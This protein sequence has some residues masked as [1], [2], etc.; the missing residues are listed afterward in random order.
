MAAS[1]SNFADNTPAGEGKNSKRRNRNESE[2]RR[3]DTFNQLIGELASLVAKRNRKI[4][5]IQAE[6]TSDEALNVAVDSKLRITT[7]CDLPEIVHLYLD[8]LGAG[9]FCMQC[10]GHIEHASTSFAILFDDAISNSL[11]MPLFY[12][13]KKRNFQIC[14]LQGK[15]LF[16][17]LD[18]ESAKSFSGALSVEALHSTC[19]SAAIQKREPNGSLRFVGITVPLSNRPESEVTLETISSWERRNSNF[20]V[21]YNTEFVCTDA[22]GCQLL[23]YSRL[24]LLGTSG[25]DYIHVDDLPQVAESHLQLIKLGTYQV[26]PHRLQTKSHQWIWVDCMAVI[27]GTHATI[28]EVRCNYRVIDMDSVRKFKETTMFVKARSIE[29][30]LLL[31]TGVSSE[32]NS[33]NPHCT[34][35]VIST[36]VCPLSVTSSSSSTVG[37]NESALSPTA[38]IIEIV[39]EIDDSFRERANDSIS[40]IA[41]EKR[42]DSSCTAKVVV[43]PLP[44]KRIRKGGSNELS[45]NVQSASSGH[46]LS[47]LSSE[48][49]L[50]KRRNQVPLAFIEH[51]PLPDSKLAAA[52]LTSAF[53]SNESCLNISNLMTSS[54]STSTSAVAPKA[55]SISPMYQQVWEELQRRSEE[56]RQQVFQKEMELRELHLKRFLASLHDDTC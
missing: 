17:L 44:S 40:I 23:G 14:E 7:G 55:L 33:L 24:D 48:A 22:E 34:T 4:D 41:P 26:R 56:L 53:N 6:S 25:Y 54:T 20:T 29:V 31:S 36:V 50:P 51:Y 11:P 32:S 1:N 9:T 13:E 39:N 49:S 43:T 2:K 19:N 52:E 5:K 35:N 30:L 15:N 37:G 42:T 21:L 27:G 46:A 3:R 8:A 45:D 12:M 28:K 18:D 47:S 10:S 16:D 38:A